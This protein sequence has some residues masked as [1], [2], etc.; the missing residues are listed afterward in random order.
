[1]SCGRPH[2]DDDWLLLACNIGEADLAFQEAR[3]RNP[4][5]EFPLL[6]TVIEELYEMSAG[7][8]DP[9]FLRA[10][11]PARRRNRKLFG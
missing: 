3:R 5:L 10:T 6:E 4:S 11:G 2:N 7:F 1:M 9:E 8:T